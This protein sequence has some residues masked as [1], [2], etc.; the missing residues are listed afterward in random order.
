MNV[1]VHDIK[2]T[3]EYTNFYAALDTNF[4][5]LTSSLPNHFQFD[6]QLDN[7]KVFMDLLTDLDIFIRDNDIKYDSSVLANF[8][9]LIYKGDKLL[10]ILPGIFITEYTYSEKDEDE[11]LTFISLN[12]RTIK[13]YQK[14]NMINSV[15]L[16]LINHKFEEQYYTI[17]LKANI[18]IYIDKNKYMSLV[19]AMSKYENI[20]NNSFKQH[21][22]E[23]QKEF[24]LHLN[25]EIMRYSV[26]T[27][28]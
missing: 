12:K 19:N 4:S 9:Y 23:T 26:F 21:K 1:S 11:I 27:V 3:D 20:E 17:H 24:L 2:S 22:L 16:G 13:I 5:L 7:K 8:T 6:V 18:R 10:S 14:S 15:V 28:F 25:V